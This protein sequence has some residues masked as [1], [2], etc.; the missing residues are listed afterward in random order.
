MNFL[1]A[2]TF[3]PICADDSWLWRRWS[4]KK[5][6]IV[7]KNFQ[8][9]QLFPSKCYNAETSLKKGNRFCSGKFWAGVPLI[10]AR[11]L[12]K[13]FGKNSSYESGFFWNLSKKKNYYSINFHRIWILHCPPIPQ[14]C[15][16]HAT[17]YGRLGTRYG[18]KNL[19]LSLMVVVFDLNH[20][21]NASK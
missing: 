18:F 20:R 4:W 16:S 6:K 7:L 21:E 12:E 19:K 13:I 3:N 10:K 2:F 14:Y 5:W 17:R 8:V 1:H 9:P 15:C 11:F